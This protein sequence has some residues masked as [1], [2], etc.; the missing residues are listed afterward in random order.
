[1]KIILM[2]VLLT[3]TIMGAEVK[4]ISPDPPFTEIIEM[5]GKNLNDPKFRRHLDGY[6]FVKPTD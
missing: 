6:E 2:T 5:V 1:M 3:A 4:Y